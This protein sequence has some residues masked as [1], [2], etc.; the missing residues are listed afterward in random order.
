MPP[1]TGRTLPDTLR[2][3]ARKLLILLP[4]TLRKSV[5][6][7]VCPHGFRGGGAN[8]PKQL[9]QRDLQTRTRCPDRP[10]GAGGRTLPPF[11]R[12]VSGLSAVRPGLRKIL[13]LGGEGNR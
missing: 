3:K 2:F 12:G 5:R 7:T 10:C 11:I 1:D 6:R 13:D 9:R 4:D 8:T